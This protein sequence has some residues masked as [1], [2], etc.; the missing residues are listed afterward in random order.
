V[1]RHV[2]F[3][4]SAALRM[5]CDS[6]LAQ[7][8]TQGVFVALAKSASQLTLRPVLSG[9]LH[10]TAQNIAAQTVRTDVRRR[11]R[12]QEAVTMNELL[13]TE[14]DA[15]WEHI[16]PHLDA[17]LGE[18]A[19]SDRDAVLLRYFERKS[20]GEMA[21]VLGVSDDAAQKRVSRAVERLRELF[22]KRGVTVGTSGLLLLISA[23]GLQAAPVGLTLTLSTATAFAGTTITSTVTKAIVMTALQK[24]V[25]ATIVVASIATPLV[26]Y[27]KAAARQRAANELHQQQASE[28]AKQ[29]AENGGMSVL[30]SKTDNLKDRLAELA[31]LRAEAEALRKETNALPRARAENRRLQAA[32]NVPEVEPSEAEKQEVNM[33]MADSKNWAIASFLYSRKNQGTFPP[34]IEKAAAFYPD[35]AK[36]ATN[37]TADQFELVYQGSLAAL[38]KPQNVIVIRQKEPL[39]YG[40]KWAKAYGYGDGHVEIHVQADTDFESWEKQYIA[41]SQSKP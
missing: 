1:R 21:Q 14:P 28:L 10:R 9:W 5:V 36:A 19:E 41:A 23:N 20:A 8:V 3:V 38:P 2:D 31:R 6:H 35:K 22:A 30:A 26:M 32:A 18:L 7:D 34:D 29:Q 4:Y 15:D 13:A 12:E 37:S 39:P 25:I 40:N 27:T 33:K 11:A 24:T 17:A 16:A